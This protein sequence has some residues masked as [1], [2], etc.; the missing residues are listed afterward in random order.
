MKTVTTAHRTLTACL[1]VVLILSACVPAAPASISQPGEATDAP[2]AQLS[3]TSAPMNLE[4]TDTPAPL[5]VEL[6]PAPDCTQPGEHNYRDNRGTYCFIFPAS[7]EIDQITEDFFIVQGPA[8]DHSSSEPLSVSFSMVSQA[9]APQATLTSLVDAYLSQSIFQ[10]MPRM[11]ERSQ[12]ELGG[13]PAEALEDVPGRLSSRLMMAVHHQMLY[14]LTFFPSD[15]P[16][17]AEGLDEL[18]AAVTGSFRFLD[19]AAPGVSTAVPTSA[20]YFEFDHSIR[21]QNDL[22]L[23][24]WIDTLTT[25]AIPATPDDLYPGS[26]P[27]YAL[28]RLLGYAGGIR[29]QLPYPLEE[30]RLM[31]FKTADFYG[32]GDNKPLGYHSQKDGLSFL[33]MGGVDP[34]FCVQPHTASEQWLP[35]LPYLNSAQVFCAKPKLVE[36]EG[37]RGIRYLTAYTQD[38]GPVLDWT[39]FYAFQGMTDDGE[40]YISAAFPVYTG[41][42]PTEVPDSYTPDKMLVDVEKQLTVLEAQPDGAFYPSLEKLDA[43][44]QS[45]RIK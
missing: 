45:L 34:A 38:A 32:F 29:Y 43:V 13:V 5:P 18:F 1:A 23:A 37:G 3:P 33:I 15:V 24:L 26:S 4:I 41:V 44:I 20:E 11:I 14:T 17:A 7:F 21:F 12:S 42:F 2:T 10:D 36:F 9:L 22:D 19:N 31:V 8:L 40:F 35:F 30:A 27:A 6:A 28:F 25:E 39:V 16:E